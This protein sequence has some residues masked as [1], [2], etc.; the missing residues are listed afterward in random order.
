LA[1]R[2]EDSHKEDNFVMELMKKLQDEPNSEEHFNMANG[3][4]FYKGRF[5]QGDLSSMKAK[6]LVLIH[7]NPLRGHSGY[8]KTLQ[9]LGRTGFGMGCRETL[10]PMCEAVT[11]TKELNMRQ[12]SLLGCYNLL[13][14]HQSHGI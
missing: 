14:S 4:L 5:F 3:L 1:R 9:G 7:D 10:K 2:I 6:V 8:L 12:A 13:K 11:L